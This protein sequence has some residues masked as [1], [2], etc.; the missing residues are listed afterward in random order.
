MYY[1]Q[2]GIYF[3]ESLFH[4]LT[5]FAQHKGSHWLS[6]CLYEL[7][8]LDLKLKLAPTFRLTHFV[9]VVKV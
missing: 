7:P 4:S 8:R 2:P 9:N 3:S 6:L 5:H 1:C